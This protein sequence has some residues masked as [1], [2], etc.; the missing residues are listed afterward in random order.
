MLIGTGKKEKKKR[1]KGRKREKEGGR[2]ERK[3][4]RKGERGRE[5]RKEGWREGRKCR[6]SKSI[7]APPNQTFFV[8]PSS[9]SFH[10]PSR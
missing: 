9:L 1:K 10:E 6:V 8:D 5:G 2:E 3:E 4:E 7:P